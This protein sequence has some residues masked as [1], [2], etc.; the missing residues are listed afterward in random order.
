MNP[1]NMSSDRPEAG[2]PP[3][4][5]SC[6]GRQASLSPDSAPANPLPSSLSPPTH[7]P[8]AQG[9]SDR[10]LES[11]RAYL[12]L[13]PK[14][15]HAAVA[16]ADVTLDAG[17]RPKPVQKGAKRCRKVQK[18]AKSAI[19]IL[20]PSCLRGSTSFPRLADDFSGKF[21]FR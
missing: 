11:L 13:G 21:K 1:E 8:R 9:E 17:A 15:R 20:C 7:F 6:A 16:L 4:L 5:N 12:E 14:R 10:A 19:L 3:V 18:S 2:T